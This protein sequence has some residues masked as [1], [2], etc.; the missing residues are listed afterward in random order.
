[1]DAKSLGLSEADWAKQKIG[2]EGT[3]HNTLGSIAFNKHEY[4][5]SVDELG[6]ATKLMPADG[7][8]WYLLGFSYYQ[9]SQNMTKDAINAI[10]QVNDMKKKKEDKAMIDEASATADALQDAAREKRELA[11]SAFATSVN[12][13]GT[14][15][16]PAMQQLTKIWQTKNNGSTDG[17]Q[18][19]IKSK[20]PAQQ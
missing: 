1:M 13:G 12:C 15:Q 16:Q 18:D 2:I 7:N 5:K 6:S 11:L 10:N 14:T 4:D 20:K 17:L 19:F 9:Q 8:S 3:L